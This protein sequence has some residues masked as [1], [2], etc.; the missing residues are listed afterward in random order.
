MP[1]NQISRDFGG[2]V[3]ERP[4]P[5]HNP[6]WPMGDEFIRFMSRAI[7]LC[8]GRLGVSDQHLEQVKS[9]LTQYLELVYQKRADHNIVVRF[10]QKD[11]SRPLFSGEFDA[12]SF[13]F[14]RSAFELLETNY[15]ENK[16]E[17][18]RARR[19]F[20]NQVGETFFN[21]LQN[22]LKLRL[23]YGLKTASDF[24]RLQKNIDGVAEFLLG[25]GYLRDKCHFT[26]EV[27][28]LQG[29]KHIL[30]APEDFLGNLKR[31]G[32]GYA[33]YIMGYPVIL[34][35]AV[36]LYQMFGEAQHHSSRTIEELFDKVG[37]RARESDDFDP[38]SFP[39]SEVV[40]LWTICL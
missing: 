9:Y 7:Y 37:L 38:S 22:H 29:G 28:V 10:I 24:V 35:S 32:V 21:S 17:V 23:P 36:Y 8:W 33:L 39:S 6:W 3:A 25:Q 5:E 19:R 15:S 1:S 26:F 34:P 11:F 12:L 27:D 30:Q 13:A 2:I 4:F 40:E 31:N 14:Y 20:T 16:A 18:I